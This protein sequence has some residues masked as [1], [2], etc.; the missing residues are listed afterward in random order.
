MTTTDMVSMCMMA[1]TMLMASAI[2]LYIMRQMSHTARKNEYEL[3]EVKQ[4]YVDLR[5]QYG[6]LAYRIEMMNVNKDRKTDYSG[7]SDYERRTDIDKVYRELVFL[8]REIREKQDAQIDY[9]RIEKIVND[10][11]CKLEPNDFSEK[12]TNTAEYEPIR[13]SVSIYTS[14]IDDA[15]EIV[16]NVLHITR[17]P[18]SGIKIA[19]NA[20]E[21]LTDDDRVHKKCNEIIELSDMIERELSVFIEKPIVG[22][23]KTEEISSRIEHDCKIIGLTANKKINLKFKLPDEK[24]MISVSKADCLM[25]CANCILENAMYYTKDNGFIDIG[26]SV[27]DGIA[28]FSITNY[29]ELIDA[30]DIDKIFSKGFSGRGSSGYGLYLAKDAAEKYLNATVTVNS[31]VGKGVKF[32]ILMKDLDML[33]KIES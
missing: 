9:K 23:D 22:D 2:V 10:A 7:F 32:S 30:N 28:E 15:K 5:Q 8:I 21:K 25:M 19:V 31:D 11:I 27:D 29:G 18:V 17:T 4:K 12:K 24:Y 3:E 33:Q 13:D 26:F 6:E 1:T 16:S 14:K 20:I